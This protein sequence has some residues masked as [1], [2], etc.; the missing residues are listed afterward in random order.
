[1]RAEAAGRVI[2]GIISATDPKRP[3]EIDRHTDQAVGGPSFSKAITISGIKL[4]VCAQRI[5]CA[6]SL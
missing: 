4:S 3:Y 6:L 5:M 2:R 1:M